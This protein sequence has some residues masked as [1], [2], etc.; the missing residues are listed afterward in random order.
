LHP[1][2]HLNQ[3][4]L[5]DALGKGQSTVSETLT[6][7]NLPEDIRSAARTNANIPKSIL[8]EAAKMKSDLSMRRKFQNY[9]AKAGKV[10]QPTDRKQ[11]LS[12]ER[13]LLVKI[14]ELSGKIST[15]PWGDWSED[16]RNDLTGALTGIRDRAD[17]LLNAMGGAPEGEETEQPSGSNLA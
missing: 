14:D 11:K 16:D 15:L 1:G 17:E 6:L 2:P 13:A 4:Q 5:A 3:Y 7:N 12:K 9:M 10:L 8:L